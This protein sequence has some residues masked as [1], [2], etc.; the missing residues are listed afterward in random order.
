VQRARRATG[1]KT[2]KTLAPVILLFI[3]SLTLLTVLPGSASAQAPPG[4]DSGAPPSDAPP[5]SGGS[6]PV[7]GSSDGPSSSG[8]SD[9]GGDGTQAP[10]SG[11]E[12]SDAPTASGSSGSYSG[13]DSAPVTESSGTTTTATAAPNGGEE[14]GDRTTSRAGTGRSSKLGRPDNGSSGK[15]DGDLKDLVKGG[16]ELKKEPDEEKPHRARDTTP[17]TREV[18]AGAFALTGASMAVPIVSGGVL[19]IGGLL[20]MSLASRRRDGDLALETS[21]GFLGYSIPLKRTLLML[22]AIAVGSS[23]WIVPA[24]APPAKAQAIDL[25]NDGIPDDEETETDPHDPDTD[26]DGI[27]DGPNDADGPLPLFEAGPDN[28]PLTHNPSQRDTDADEA[29]NA[30]DPDDDNDGLLDA[31]EK[32][33]SPRDPDS[34]NDL[35]SDGPADP[36]ASGPITAGPDNCPLD[37]NADQLDSDADGTGDACEPLDFA[38]PDP[39]TMRNL[40]PFILEEAF[41]PEDQA[42]GFRPF[43]VLFDVKWLPT[44]DADTGVNDYTLYYKKS[45]FLETDFSPMEPLGSEFRTK[46]T[47]RDFVGSQGNSLCFS[48]AARDHANNFSLLEDKECT[49]LPIDDTTMNRVGSWKIKDNADAYLDDQS[50]SKKKGSYLW[51]PIERVRRFALVVTKCGRCGTVEVKRWTGSKYVRL[52]KGKYSLKSSN[53]TKKSVVIEVADLDKS[54]GGDLVVEVTS[55]RKPVR[56]EGIGASKR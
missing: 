46:H 13:T 27:S 5:D 42:P 50:V 36:D 15:I 55:R 19:I 14:R 8:S 2:S 52:G 3:A 7:D 6:P 24:F 45:S 37:D 30:C 10:A 32:N 21:S 20:L 40:P 23:L 9:S 11:G 51:I 16:D 26:D 4:D 28:C 35:I 54:V 34:D 25:D 1:G 56:I 44:T 33:T 39:V 49:A 38:P 31:S 29:G 17:A 22:V 48:V 18:S 12:S 53:G 47:K 41:Y 43:Q